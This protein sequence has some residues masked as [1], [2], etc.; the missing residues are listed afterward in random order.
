[1]LGLPLPPLAAGGGEVTGGHGAQD[2]L[3]AARPHRCLR[4]SGYANKGRTVRQTERPGGLPA[5]A[6]PKSS[7]AAAAKL[8]L[9]PGYGL[10]HD[11][12]RQNREMGR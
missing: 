9:W 5:M 7:L 11:N 4:I 3:L 2:V 6:A 12:E 1:M 10:E 8:A